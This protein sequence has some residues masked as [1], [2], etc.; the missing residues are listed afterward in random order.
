MV[1]IV[2]FCF[3]YENATQYETIF[4]VLFFAAG[5]K[6]LELR[7]AMPKTTIISLERERERY[8]TGENETTVQDRKTFEL[9][10]KRNKCK[11]FSKP[12]VCVCVCVGILLVAVTKFGI[13]SVSLELRNIMEMFFCFVFSVAPLRPFTDLTYIFCDGERTRDN[14]IESSERSS[15][16]FKFKYWPSRPR[17]FFFFFF[18]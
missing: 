2:L 16:I 5:Q 3:F 11:C 10:K 8:M 17:S 9:L 13:A 15:L 7:L 1:V 14:R 4:F 12:L 18:F 6:R